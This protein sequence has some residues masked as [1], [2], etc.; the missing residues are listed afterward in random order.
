MNK[1]KAITKKE[2]KP[3]LR[4]IMTREDV[5]DR[6]IDVLGEMEA[7]AYISSVLIAVTQSKELQECNANSIIGCALRAATMRLSV[8]PGMAQAY[9]VPFKNRSKDGSWTYNA[10]LI[11]GWKGL[12]H[13]AIRT[14]EYRHLNLTPIYDTDILVEDPLTG[15]HDLKR[16]NLPLDLAKNQPKPDSKNIVGYLLYFELMPKHQHARGLEKSFYMTCEECEEHGKKYSKNYSSQSSV[17]KTDPHA[18]YRKT[19][20]RMGLKY[21]Y[22]DPMDILSIETND[23]VSEPIVGEFIEGGVSVES[24]PYSNENGEEASFEEKVKMLGFNQNGERPFSPEGL[25]KFIDMS[26]KKFDGDTVGDKKR[27]YL[28]GIIDLCF[29]HNGAEMDRHELCSFLT[30]EPSTK[31]IA[32]AYIL[33][34]WDWLDPTTNGDEIFIPGS[35]AMKEANSALRFARKENGQQE[36]FEGQSVE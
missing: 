13:M 17:W 26:A 19:V 35:M 30:G 32:D 15:V 33:A 8:D 23:E 3:N 11:I 6:F 14:G 16:F 29:A 9:L 31:K 24:E 21:G 18:M 7:N 1:E 2:E 5:K 27:N 12:W 36:L 25:K 22:L 4:A 28:A 20:V 34:L 10:T